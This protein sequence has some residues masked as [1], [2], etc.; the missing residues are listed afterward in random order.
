MITVR[1]Y[2]DSRASGDRPA[3]VKVSITKRGDTA[4]ISTGVRVLPSQWDKAGQRVIG[5]PQAK[6]FN[7]FLLRFR[8]SIEDMVRD[9]VLS[10][11]AADLPV[12]DIKNEVSA[13]Y[14]GRPASLSLNDY[15]ESFLASKSDSTRKTYS[16]HLRIIKTYDPAAG[17]R[18]LSSFSQAWVSQLDSWLSSHYSANTRRQVLAVLQTLFKRAQADRFTSADPLK[19]VRLSYVHTRKRNLTLAHFRALWNA[20]PKS[21]RE[22]EALDLFRFSFLA[23]AMNTVDIAALT[24]SSIFNGRIEYDRAKTGKQYSVKIVPEL[25]ALIDKYSSDNRLFSPFAG[26]TDYGRLVVHCDHALAN[27]S[28]RLGLPRVSLYWARH[29]WASFASE[30]DIPVDIISDALGHSHGARVTMVYIH[31]DQRKVD[32]ANRRVIDYAL[33]SPASNP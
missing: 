18:P 33:Y 32:E 30:L 24:P 21:T 11:R 4:Y 14:N 28:K 10:G 9:M 25:Q 15:F 27:I 22:A 20:E 16:G 7:G 8:L 5:H 26:Y 29:T 3:P 19:G 6:Q 13:A 12:T 17:A 23:I 1:L 31:Q 2:L